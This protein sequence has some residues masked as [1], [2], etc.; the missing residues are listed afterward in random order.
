[1]I[2]GAA[3]TAAMGTCLAAPLQRGRTHWR[4]ND[5]AA[6]IFLL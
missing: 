6:G 3:I 4:G 1:M 5:G 2:A